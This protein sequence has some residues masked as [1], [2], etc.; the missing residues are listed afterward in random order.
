MSHV[1]TTRLY[2]CFVEMYS[3][4]SRFLW[5]HKLMLLP[6]LLIYLPIILSFTY[7]LSLSSYFL[8][9]SLSLRPDIDTQHSLSL[10]LSFFPD[11]S[12]HHSPFHKL[13]LTLII[14]SLTFPASWYISDIISAH[15]SPFH[16]LKKT[17]PFSHPYPP[18]TYSL[19]LSPIS[20]SLSSYP[21][22]LSWSSAS[23]FDCFAGLSIPEGAENIWEQ[24]FTYLQKQW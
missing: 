2:C 9:L 1:K 24:T 10:S 20:L 3:C 6:S 4:A 21:L 17:L 22:S 13:T 23:L 8:L 11:I 18:G 14:F 19:P 16:P 12:A 15:H 5:L 7:S